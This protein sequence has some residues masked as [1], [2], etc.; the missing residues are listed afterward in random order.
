MIDGKQNPDS[1]GMNV[2]LN[3]SSEAFGNVSTLPYWVIVFRGSEVIRV[4]C[5]DV[6]KGDLLLFPCSI[7]NTLTHLDEPFSIVEL[8]FV[9]NGKQIKQSVGIEIETVVDIHKDN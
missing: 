2:I 7:E 3:A 4:F 9:C 1:L 6:R 8:P 5:E